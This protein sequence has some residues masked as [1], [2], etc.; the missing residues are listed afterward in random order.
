MLVLETIL[1]FAV[2]PALVGFGIVKIFGK[3]GAK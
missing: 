2:I 1:F 3:G